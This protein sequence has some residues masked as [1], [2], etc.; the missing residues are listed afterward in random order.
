MAPS[1]P[2]PVAISGAL[3]IVVTRPLPLL[4]ET[5]AL[6]A[7][8]SPLAWRPPMAAAVAGSIP[9][10]VLYALAGAVA[11]SAASTTIVFAAVIFVAAI[12]WLI[13][14]RFVQPPEQDDQSLELSGTRPDPTR[15]KRSDR[16]PRLRGRPHPHRFWRR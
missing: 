8:A 5:T 14:H 3:A 12:F 11:A 7:G 15:R 2:V 16:M 4:A 6:A 9:A 1:L 13:S 10:A